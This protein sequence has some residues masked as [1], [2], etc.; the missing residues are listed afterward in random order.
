MLILSSLK[1]YI[2]NFPLKRLHGGLRGSLFHAPKGE[3]CWL[4]VW[5]ALTGSAGR[6]FVCSCLPW[7]ASVMDSKVE[8]RSAEGVR[9][10]RCGSGVTVAQGLFPPIQCWG[11][12]LVPGADGAGMGLWGFMTWVWGQEGSQTLTLVSFVLPFEDPFQGALQ[13]EVCRG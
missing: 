7:A 3:V 8:R 2:F 10:D 5:W 11:T 6:R 9:G 12:R 13:G 4:A 1:C